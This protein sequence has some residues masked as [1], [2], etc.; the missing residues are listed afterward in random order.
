MVPEGQVVCDVVDELGDDGVVEG[1][2]GGEPR[3]E[4][5]PQPAGAGRSDPGL[6]PHD[7]HQRVGPLPL[8]VHDRHRR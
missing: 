2:H 5:A 6:G 7:P 3:D 8:H 4:A 1:V